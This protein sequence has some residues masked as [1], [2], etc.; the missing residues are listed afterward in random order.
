MLW[1]DAYVVK[2]DLGRHFARVHYNDTLVGKGEERREEG[3]KEEG[4]GKR[5]GEGRRGE[6]VYG[7]K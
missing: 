2:V 6:N 3:R 4:V 5:S 7:L 1:F